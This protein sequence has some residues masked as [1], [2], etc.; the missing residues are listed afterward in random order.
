[1]EVP[2]S[3][4]ANVGGHPLV[5]QTL[6]RR[7]IDTPEAAQAFLDPAAYSP[8]DPLDFPDLVIA[9]YRLQQAI[10]CGDRIAVW[11]DFDADGQTSTALL[12]EVLKTLGADVVFRVPSR[13]E[14]HGLHRQGLERLIADGAHVILTC[15]TGITAHDEVVRANDLGAEVIITDHHE[16]GASLPPA[17]AVVNPH[18]LLPDHPMVTLPGV[19]V[20]Y[21]LARALDPGAADAALDLVALGTVADVA[22]VTGDARYLVQRGLVALRNTSRLGLQAVYKAAGL[23][24][25]GITEEH[26]GF[27]LGPRLNALGRLSDASQG[28]ELLTTKDSIRARTLATEVEGLNARRRWQTK[29][30]SEAALAQIEREP[31]LLKY[32]ALVLSH[33]RWPGGIV[34]IVANRLAERYERPA[35]LI[36]APPDGVARG[37]GRSV[38]GVDLIGALTDCEHL[39]LGFG[40][41]KAAA[42][43][44]IEPERIPE[45]R[46]TLSRAVADR[47]KA[48]EPPAL[49]IDAYVELSELTLDL[50]TEL[51]RLA[52]FGPGNPPLT[53]ATR[54]LAIVSE[55]T[56]GRTKEHLRLTVEDAD[57]Q[58]QTVYWW[59]GA[60]WTLPQGHFDLAFHVRANDYRGELDVQVEWVEA[61]QVGPA[62]VEIQPTSSIAVW[63]HRDASDPAQVLGETVAQGEVQVWAE[64]RTRPKDDSV[65]RDELV[66]RRRLA[67]W[68]SPPS[69]QV[70]Q[71]AL[72]QAQPEEIF[73]FAQKP[74]SDERGVLLHD[75]AGMVKYSLRARAGVTDLARAAAALAQ[76]RAAVKAGLELLAA[77]GLVDVV[78]RGNS[79]W[80][81]VQGKGLPNLDR[82]RLAVARLDAQLAETEAYRDYFQNAPKTAL[83]KLLV[84]ARG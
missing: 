66:P 35:V 15:D 51:S 41:H 81:M 32:E 57:Q 34:G 80:R 13:H 47:S 12:L 28:V 79:T 42:G 70:L 49:S 6:A 59:Q 76:T 53:L 9:V 23:R 54:D 19:G 75:L 3:L 20:A 61:R 77:S 37:S 8:S 18:R 29:Q 52:P 67:I 25:E 40:G 43:F 44:S 63:D 74:G 55:A 11:G 26:I 22:T 68:S 1:V 4:I 27:V 39:L 30:V 72:D 83:E 82:Q 48:V 78:E 71:S 60:A 24:R 62:A 46:T 16:L 2:A 84:Q 7:G 64:G 45:L 56:I 50:V 17:L 33:P 38:P 31:D 10:R 69:L 73:V 36:S 5:A 58:R 65:G 21:E 14:G